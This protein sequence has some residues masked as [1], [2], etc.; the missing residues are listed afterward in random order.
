MTCSTGRWAD[1]AATVQPN[2]E[3]KLL[4]ENK[5]NNATEWMTHTV[6]WF[7][8]D[9]TMR[10]YHNATS[11]EDRSRLCEAACSNDNLDLCDIAA[12]DDDL[13]YDLNHVVPTVW[14]FLPMADP[15]VS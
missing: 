11:E 3:P 5:T 2:W 14:R 8:P 15:K 10:V 7:R 6:H 13:D 4:K 12:I 1:S 9:W